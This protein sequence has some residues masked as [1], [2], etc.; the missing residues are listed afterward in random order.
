[1]RVKVIGPVVALAIAIIAVAAWLGPGDHRSVL[2]DGGA[3]AANPAAPPAQPDTR[4]NAFT[5]QVAT[6]TI[7]PVVPDASDPAAGTAPFDSRAEAVQ[8][9]VA[10]LSQL[11]LTTDPH[12]LNVILSEVNNPDP[13]IRKAAVSAAVDF[14]S[15][16][17]IP[18]LQNAL[19]AADDLNE[20]VRIQ[21]A[22]D[23][24]RLPSVLVQNNNSDPQT[25]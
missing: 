22:I 16:D 10:E 14:G 7:Q 15:R 19:L 6:R 8:T 20:K 11:G 5:S 24:L 23:F 21:N 17:A 3:V 9:R 18:S 2:A 4:P 1:M 12:S 13:A 25:K